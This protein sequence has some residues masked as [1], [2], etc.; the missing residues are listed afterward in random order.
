[1]QHAKSLLL[2][3]SMT[4]KEIATHCGYEN[5]DY[6]RRLFRRF[7]DMQP[8]QFRSLHLKQHTNAS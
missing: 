6:F 8:N 3:T 5:V 1:M 4:I 7:F 2:L